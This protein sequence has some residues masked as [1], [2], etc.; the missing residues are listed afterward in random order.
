[1][2][3]VTLIENTTCLADLTCE[4][5]LSL[6]IETDNR[7]ILFD[8]GQTGAFADN[9]QKLGIDLSKVDLAI[10]SHGHY[11]HSGGFAR[12]LEI[13]QTARIY[14]NQNAIKPYYN[15]IGGY[16]GMAPELMES[17]RLIFTRD[18]DQLGSGMTLYSCND[19]PRV[20]NM[21]SF[22]LQVMENGQLI[23]DDFCHEQYLLIEQGGKRVCISGCS[24]KGI[25]NIAQW[26]RPDVMVGGFHFMKV[27]TQ[28]EGA[29]FL[30][31]AARELMQYPTVY[32]TGHCTGREQFAY[33]KAC[34]GDRLQALS[35]GSVIWA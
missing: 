26:F 11:D 19:R 23:P 15:G 20:Y 3:I 24:H 29:A 10:L 33:M 8:A 18:V 34:M 4:H 12:F 35:T 7:K 16:I 21:D 27:E 32:Y 14:V 25:L 1:M 13:N 17:G 6:Y 31:E 5:G 28:G 30:E 22:G 2:R 9:A